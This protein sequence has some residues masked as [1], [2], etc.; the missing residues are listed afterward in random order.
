MSNEIQVAGNGLQVRPILPQDMDSTWRM[1]KI[2]AASGLAPKGVSTVE[3]IFT[4][5]QMG[6]EVGLSPMQALQNI[7]V[8]NGR[9]TIWGDAQLGLVRGS[10]LLE[11]F[12]EKFEGDG[13]KMVAYCI[14]KRKGEPAPITGE[15]SV[16]DAV[17]AALWNKAGPWTQY[18]KRMLK[19]RAR[20]FALR[21]GFSDILKGIYSTEEMQG[22]QDVTPREESA[23]IQD[24]NA[25]FIKV[26]A[27]TATADHVDGQLEMVVDHIADISKMVPENHNGEVTKMVIMPIPER[28][29]PM[30]HD[31]N[32]MVTGADWHA[33]AVTVCEDIKSAPTSDWIAQYRKKHESQLGN[34]KKNHPDAFKMFENTLQ[35]RGAQLK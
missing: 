24:L 17:V 15:F 33:F 28:I 8:V 6:A 23:N 4:A 34:M 7:A 12:E 16:K 14:V 29:V 3:A 22:M 18:P 32:G 9:P 35:V 10:G 13:D 30:R 31:E 11:S 19:M 21:D 1:S 20:G 27:K 5:I 2:I 26:V 25:K